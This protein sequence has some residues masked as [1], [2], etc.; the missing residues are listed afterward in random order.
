[1]QLW[2]YKMI[3]IKIEQCQRYVWLMIEALQKRSIL[4]QRGDLIVLMESAM[5]RRLA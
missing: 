1:M 2:S 5:L 3:H 4:R